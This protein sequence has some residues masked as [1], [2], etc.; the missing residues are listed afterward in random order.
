MDEIRRESAGLI[1]EVLDSS[2]FYIA[3]AKTDSRSF[4]N[5]TFRTPSEELDREFVAGAA[6]EGLVNLKGHRITGGIRASLYNSMPMEGAAAM[7]Y[8]MK[9]FEAQNRCLK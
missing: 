9:R 2:S 8:Y 5:A 7:G 4:M 1:Y 3:K 6:K